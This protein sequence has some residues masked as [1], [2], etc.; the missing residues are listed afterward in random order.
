MD[1]KGEVE[2]LDKKRK[3]KKAKKRKEITTGMVGV[4]PKDG[5]PMSARKYK[6]VLKAQSDAMNALAAAGSSDVEKA[7]EAHRVRKEEEGMRVRRENMG[8][9]ETTE[10]ETGRTFYWNK[11]TGERRWDDPAREKQ[12]ISEGGW[13]ETKDGEG[14]VYYYNEKGETRWDKPGEV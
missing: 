6:K 13:Y 14:N 5:G 3:K 11:G 7:L 1:V 10:Q 12:T 4:P 8:W 9:L 2:G